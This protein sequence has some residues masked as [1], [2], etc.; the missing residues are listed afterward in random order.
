MNPLALEAQMCFPLYAA[1]RAMQRAYRPLLTELGLSYPQY[2]TMLVLWERDG[3]PVNAIGTRLH[4]DSGTLTPLLKR[5][6]RRGVIERRRR[7][8]DERVVEV[9]LTE[10]GHQLREQAEQ[11]PLQLL[12]KVDLPREDVAELRTTLTELLARLESA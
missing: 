3:M 4:L 6:E 7:A 2:L 1:A 8:E 10:E 12:C 11:V 5:L 9:Y